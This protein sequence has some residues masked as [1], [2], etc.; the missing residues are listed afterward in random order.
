MSNKYNRKPFVATSRA[1]MMKSMFSL[2]IVSMTAC[3]ISAAQPTPARAAAAATAPDTMDAESLAPSLRSAIRSNDLSSVRMLIK[4]GAEVNT[5][6]RDESDTTPLHLAV[7]C[8]CKGGRTNIGWE[9]L[10]KGGDVNGV[11]EFNR[12][13]L[14]LCADAVRNDQRR[15]ACLDTA[16]ALLQAGQGA[17]SPQR[18]HEETSLEDT[19]RWLQ[20][21]L[22]SAGRWTDVLPEERDMHH[23]LELSWHETRLTI[24]KYVTHVYRRNPQL[25]QGEEP[26]EVYLLDLAA[27]RTNSCSLRTCTHAEHP[28]AGVQ[29][30]D[31]ALS[32]DGKLIRYADG[33]GGRSWMTDKLWIVVT[34]KDLAKRMIR[35]IEHAAVLAKAAEPF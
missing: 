29:L 26:S 25:N 12:T 2:A 11:D 28:Y 17:G 18:D 7:A 1:P 16:R 22:D 15:V 27:I 31:L 5:H 24:T 4:K 6:F 33:D 32:T 9:L 21:K 23:R 34:D 3:T 13:P 8:A 35:A 14:L 19:L 30:Y 20:R 10:G